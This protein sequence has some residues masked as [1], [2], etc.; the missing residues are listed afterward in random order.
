MADI[1]Q[2][3]I[4]SGEVFN[5]KDAAARED[6][7]KIK[8][9]ISGG[10]HF[11]GVTET[12]L[13]DGSTK[14][15]ITIEGKQHI[16]EKGDIVFYLA[17][18]FIWD[19]AKWNLFG[20]LR[21]LKALAYK[22]EASGKYTPKGR[23]S[24]QTFSGNLMTVTGR[25]RPYGQITQPTFN[26]TKE[27]LEFTGSASGDI[28]ID[29]TPEGTVSKPQVDVQMNTESIR[30]MTGAGTLPSLTTRVRDDILEIGFSAGSLP[31]MGE[32]VRVATGVNNVSV[33]DISFTGKKKSMSGHLDGESISY[34]CEYTPKGTITTPR[35]N[36]TET[37]IILKGTPTGMISKAGFDGKEETITV[38]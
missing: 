2:I 3:E 20:D 7:S 25:H 30:P 37:D 31:T 4:P 34:S 12:V 17:K 23:I 10:V 5:I 29:Y 16:P 18:E 14:N 6:I 28:S 33:S 11:L 35:F 13:I 36:G 21:G 22:D 19:G 8:E 26:G 15:P 9:S 27:T 24:K 1:S 38:S 32:S